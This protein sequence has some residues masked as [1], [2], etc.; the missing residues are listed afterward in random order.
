MCSEPCPDILLLPHLYGRRT[1]LS[2][3]HQAPPCTWMSWQGFPPGCFLKQLL[4]AGLCWC[5]FHA[6]LGKQLLQEPFN[7][8]PLRLGALVAL[9][10]ALGDFCS[11]APHFPLNSQSFYSPSLKSELG[12]RTVCAV[13]VGFLFK[14]LQTCPIPAKM[15]PLASLYCSDCYF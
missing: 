8:F 11:L 12:N 13:D 2:G 1:G 3:M 9:P 7:P 15:W 5:L 4:F 14:C 6:L 10:W